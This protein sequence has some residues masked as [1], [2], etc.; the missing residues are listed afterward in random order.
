MVMIIV[1]ILVI[2]FSYAAI[3]WRS[4]LIQ[5]DGFRVDYA[6]LRNRSVFIPWG[7][8]VSFRADT[9]RFLHGGKS[10]PIVLVCTHDK[11]IE[12]S[13]WL[14]SGLPHLIRTMRQRIGDREKGPNQSVQTRT[15]SG[16]V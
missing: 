1:G 8:I 11:E 6:V 13:G 2:Y 4:L 12:L 14:V 5:K 10:H 16:P 7:S 15:T 9:A 3:V